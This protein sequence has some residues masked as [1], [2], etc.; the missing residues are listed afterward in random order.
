MMG[1]GCHTSS[2]KVPSLLAIGLANAGAA[3]YQ[4]VRSYNAHI[5]AAFVLR[6]RYVFFSLCVLVCACGVYLATCS[7]LYASLLTTRVCFELLYRLL[8]LLLLILYFVLSLGTYLV[9]TTM[10]KYSR[11][12]SSYR[13]FRPVSASYTWLLIVLI[14]A[15][16]REVLFRSCCGQ[17][18]CSGV[19]PV[20][21]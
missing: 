13:H 18:I 14:G 19:Q 16:D 20:A 5:L 12:Q 9:C 11:E 2:K 21:K 3:L 17:K 1:T 4:E 7:L 15:D 8:L 6:W 10:V